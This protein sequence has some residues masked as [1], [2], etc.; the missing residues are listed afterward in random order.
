MRDQIIHIMLLKVQVTL[1][2]TPL[3]HKELTLYQIYHLPARFSSES[4][5]SDTL[6]LS[7]PFFVRFLLSPITVPKTTPNLPRSM[8]NIPWCLY[9]LQEQIPGPSAL[10]QLQHHGFL[11]AGSAGLQEIPHHRP[12]TPGVSPSAPGSAHQGKEFLKFSFKTSTSQ[13]CSFRGGR[14]SFSER[15]HLLLGDIFSFFWVY[16]GNKTAVGHRWM[17]S[18]ICDCIF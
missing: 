15:L 8:V 16:W 3:L 9:R 2:K 4:S 17:R 6:W 12:G 5:C 14:C 10:G 18:Y 1:S 13:S 7:P 11:L